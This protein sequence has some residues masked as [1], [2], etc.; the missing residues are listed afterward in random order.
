MSGQ[1]VVVLSLTCIMCGV[2]DSILEFI[3]GMSFTGS[4]C[5][6]GEIPVRDMSIKSC[7]CEAVCHLQRVGRKMF[8]CGTHLQEIEGF[9]HSILLQYCFL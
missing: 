5:Q 1:D 4:F 6:R 2:K 3:V 8:A 7:S 9:L